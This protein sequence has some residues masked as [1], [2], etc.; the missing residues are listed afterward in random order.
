VLHYGICQETERLIGFVRGYTPTVSIDKLMKLLDQVAASYNRQSEMN[1]TELIKLLKQHERLILNQEEQKNELQDSINDIL[2]FTE[3]VAVDAKQKAR[4]TAR[5]SK[6]R[7]NA[8]S[9]TIETLLKRR[10][11][12]KENPE[13]VDTN[14]FKRVYWR[15]PEEYF[16]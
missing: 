9:N 12:D 13:K 5:A 2:E 8:A 4:L 6:Q 16:R 15:Q 11:S 14:K 7:F 3:K 1:K 10:R